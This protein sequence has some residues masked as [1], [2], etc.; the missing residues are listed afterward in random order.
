MGSPD[1]LLQTP[2]ALD[3]TPTSYGLG[4]IS[5]DMNP[6]VQDGQAGMSSAALMSMLND[7]SFD[8]NALFNTEFVSTPGPVS[9]SQLTPSGSVQ[10]QQP[11]GGAQPTNSGFNGTF[12]PGN[13]NMMGLVSSP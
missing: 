7:G 1:P 9:Q 6:E 11:P 13:A 2:Y 3:A 10:Q 12:V 8:M 4:D 5:L